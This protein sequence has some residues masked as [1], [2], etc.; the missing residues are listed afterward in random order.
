MTFDC[1]T[2]LLFL[3]QGYVTETNHTI[4]LVLYNLLKNKTKEFKLGKNNN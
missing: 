2:L 4:R 1:V 3:I